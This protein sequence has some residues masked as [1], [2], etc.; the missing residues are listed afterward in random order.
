M[1]KT[2]S[3]SE[4]DTLC[5]SFIKNKEKMNDLILKD[6]AFQ[7]LKSVRGSP[8]YWQSQMYK[9]LASVKQYGMF[10]FFITLSSAD[11]HWPDLIMAI[12][13]QKGVNKSSDEIKQMTYE[14][15]CQILRY[16]PVTA[17]RHFDYKLNCFIKDIIYSSMEPI[18]KVKHY[19]YR[20]EFQVLLYYAIYTKI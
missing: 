8:P 16:N 13:S 3:N 7:F 2:F 17:A 5:S 1:R 4:S 18:G 10:T 9:L 6:F 12:L 20:I 11:L 19:A 14:E 15:K